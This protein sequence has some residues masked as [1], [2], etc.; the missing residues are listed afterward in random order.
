MD[1]SRIASSLF[2][3]KKMAEDLKEAEERNHSNE[4]DKRR[5]FSL[6]NL[7]GSLTFTK[8]ESS[9]FQF[10]GTFVFSH[11]TTLPLTPE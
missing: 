3:R 1:F 10:Y 9:N 4:F 2:D 6:K 8:R 7:S 5:R 11:E